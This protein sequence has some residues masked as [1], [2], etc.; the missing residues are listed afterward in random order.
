[1]RMKRAWAKPRKRATGKDRQET[2]AA[3]AKWQ[4]RDSH[5]PLSIYRSGGPVLPRTACVVRIYCRQHRLPPTGRPHSVETTGCAR[6]R[7]HYGAATEGPRRPVTS[8]PTSSTTLAVAPPEKAH[9]PRMTAA[10][11]AA[12]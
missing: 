10:T 9:P 6:M 1:M 7:D 11:T 8:T 3:D 12:I 5:L 2:R 4:V